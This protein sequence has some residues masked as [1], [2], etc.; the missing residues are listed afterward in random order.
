MAVGRCFG[1]GGA[2]GKPSSLKEFWAFLHLSWRE[3]Y[4]RQEPELKPS[5]TQRIPS[6]LDKR[7]QLLPSH[8]CLELPTR[9]MFPT[10]P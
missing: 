7:Q 4:S 10:C 2:G 5:A 9:C 3:V 1:L 6:M 8:S